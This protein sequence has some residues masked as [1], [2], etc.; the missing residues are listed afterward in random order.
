MDGQ[1]FSQQ[2]PRLSYAARPK[3]PTAR[4]LIGVDIPYLECLNYLEHQ[5]RGFG[6]A[7]KLPVEGENALF[8]ARLGR[9]RR[10]TGAM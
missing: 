10:Q 2:M 3:I 5:N 8:I 4:T 9:R 7:G 6:V 1:T